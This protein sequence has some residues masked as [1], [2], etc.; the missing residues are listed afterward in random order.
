MEDEQSVEDLVSRILG[1]EEPGSFPNVLEHVPKTHLA[2][3]TPEQDAMA[4]AFV[5][6]AAPSDT[7][8]LAFHVATDQRFHAVPVIT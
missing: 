1:S 2:A 7:M 4:R 5:A 3:L 6:V 8:A